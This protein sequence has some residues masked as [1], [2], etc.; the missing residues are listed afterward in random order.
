MN[1]CHTDPPVLVTLWQWG[2]VGLG[3]GLGQDRGLEHRAYVC[4]EGS[5][6]LHLKES[7]G[8]KFCLSGWHPIYLAGV[9]FL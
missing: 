8:W 7:Q 4:S 1:N 6:F 2:G 9:P 3:V 5:T